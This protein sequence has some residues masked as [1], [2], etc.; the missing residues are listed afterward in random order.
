MDSKNNTVLKAMADSEKVKS[1]CIRQ[2]CL[3]QRDICLGCH[4]SLQDILNWSGSSDDEKRAI[5]KQAAARQVERN[6]RYK[7][8]K[9]GI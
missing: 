9:S 3:D 7:A 1:P 4:R 8:F 2:C 5:L 6:Q